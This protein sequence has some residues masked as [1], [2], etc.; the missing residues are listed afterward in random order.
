MAL[1]RTEINIL[2]DVVSDRPRSEIAQ[3]DVRRKSASGRKL[4]RFAMFTQLLGAMRS[5][6]GSRLQVGSR[7]GSLSAFVLPSR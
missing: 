1:C 3:F 2:V 4:D 5:S 6:F 7:F